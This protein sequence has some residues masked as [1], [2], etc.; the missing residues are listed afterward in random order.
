[1]YFHHGLQQELNNFRMKIAAYQYLRGGS[2]QLHCGNDS[3]PSISWMYRQAGE[4]IAQILKGSNPAEMP[5][6]Q[7]TQFE[8]VNGECIRAHCASHAASG[9]R[10]SD[11]IAI[12]FVA[13]R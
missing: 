13:A 4:Y 10:R 2:E 5:V 9:R 6:L 11:R 1:M 3:G 12:S 8:L 7:P